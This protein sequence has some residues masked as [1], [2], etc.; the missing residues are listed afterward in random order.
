MSSTGEQEQV[1]TV[2]R[3][4]DWTIDWFA[5][6]QVEGGRL[7]AELLLARAMNC[8]KIDLY[9]RYDAAVTDEERATFRELVRRATD[10]TPIAYLLGRREFY[11]L[12]FEVT[13]AVLVP[14]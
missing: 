8:R 1:W 5:R 12:E 2:G 9:T 11:S 4:L 10:H 7:A 6:K 14:Q 3:L 13:P